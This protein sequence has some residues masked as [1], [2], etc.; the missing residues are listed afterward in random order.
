MFVMDRC[1]EKKSCITCWH[2]GGTDVLW[3]LIANWVDGGGCGCSRFRCAGEELLRMRGG[4]CKVW[5]VRERTG[6]FM[7]K[8]SKM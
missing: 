4:F 2:H 6:C 3:G 7:Y 5:V 8:G 1:V